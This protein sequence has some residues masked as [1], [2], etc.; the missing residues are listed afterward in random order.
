MSG[1]LTDTRDII[2]I[3]LQK[4]NRWFYMCLKLIKES[5]GLQ[6]IV[7]GIL[8]VVFSIYGLPEILK[9]LILHVN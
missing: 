9:I 3:I 7:W 5:K 1:F 2:V 6:A 8:F 4:V